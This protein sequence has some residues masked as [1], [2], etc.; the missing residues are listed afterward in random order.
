M[1]ACLAV[2]YAGWVRYL[3]LGRGEALFYRPLLGIPLPMAVMPV[4]YFLAAALLLGSAW[5]L[6]AACILGG[7]HITVT[8][9]NSPDNPS[10]ARLS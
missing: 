9:L 1:A 7:G 4:V 5:L 6:L 8:W 3:L 10:R 2:Y